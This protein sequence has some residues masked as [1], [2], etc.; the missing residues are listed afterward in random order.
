MSVSTRH[1]APCG[2][3]E[4]FALFPSYA[5]DAGCAAASRGLCGYRTLHS[6][7]IYE[8]WSSITYWENVTSSLAKLLLPSKFFGCFVK[9]NV[10]FRN[11]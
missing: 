7:N 3:K 11:N 1:W 10:H 2:V 5:I 4:A 9:L 8:R 6:V